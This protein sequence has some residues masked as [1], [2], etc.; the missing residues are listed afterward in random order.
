MN[1]GGAPPTAEEKAGGEEADALPQTRDAQAWVYKVPHEQW[2][3]PRM[4]WALLVEGRGLGPGGNSHRNG[5][6]E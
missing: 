2:G 6:A 1:W 4:L 5:Q 3:P